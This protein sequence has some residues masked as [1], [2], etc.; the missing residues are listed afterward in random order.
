M[1]WSYGSEH[2]NVCN[3][4]GSASGAGT[5]LVRINP[6]TAELVDVGPLSGDSNWASSL[7][8]TH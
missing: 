3:N 7:A 6:M 1:S 5:I 8:I 4:V 2:S